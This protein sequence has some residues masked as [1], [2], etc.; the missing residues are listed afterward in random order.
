MQQSGLVPDVIIYSAV[1]SACEKCQQLQQAL[2]I[3]AVMQPAGLVHDVIT[4]GA[5]ICA[6]EKGEKWQQ[7]FG[8]LAVMQQSGHLPNVIRYNAAISA[9]EKGEQWQQALG[10]LARMRRSGRSVSSGA[11][12][13]LMIEGGVEP[14]DAVTYDAVQMA[15]NPAPPRQQLRISIW[16]RGR[17]HSIEIAVRGRTADDPKLCSGSAD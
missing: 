1:I 11:G 8:L 16:A 17:P 4:Y 14:D 3:L 10:L 9:C 15:S 2:G 12:H 7:A 6:C 13:G 5:A